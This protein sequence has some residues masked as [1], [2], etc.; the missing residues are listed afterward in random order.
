MRVFGGLLTIN[1]FSVGFLAGDIETR[2]RSRTA[3]Y[4]RTVTGKF[5]IREL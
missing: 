2:R 4:L 3:V 1:Y 5:F